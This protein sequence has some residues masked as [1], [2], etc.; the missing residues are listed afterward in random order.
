MSSTSSR[1]VF[2]VL[3]VLSVS[4]AATVALVRRW[5]KA[6]EAS[7]A[8]KI[9]RSGARIVLAVDIGSSSVRCSAYTDAP[10]PSLI[11]GC[12]VQIKHAVVNQ[13]NGTADAHKVVELVESAVD[14]CFG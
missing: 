13:D 9:V 14:Q 10:S 12:A 8:R 7:Q 2:R 3:F 5:K 6:Q 4:A 1:A 11:P